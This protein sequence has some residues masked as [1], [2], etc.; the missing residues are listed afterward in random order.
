MQLIE[1]EYFGGRPIPF[2]E[3]EA[4]LKDEVAAAQSLANLYNQTCN[5]AVGVES[6]EAAFERARAFAA[7]WV[8]YARA[9]IHEKMD[10]REHAT[11]TLRQVIGTDPR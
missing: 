9:D 5:L 2:A 8:A 10:E 7:E 6:S 4:W 1:R 11:S 3:T